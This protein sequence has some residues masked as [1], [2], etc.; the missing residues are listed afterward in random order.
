VGK[1]EGPILNGPGAFLQEEK[2]EGKGMLY[3]LAYREGK[4]ESASC[5]LPPGQKRYL[6]FNDLENDRL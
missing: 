5:S 1:K 6:E 3:Y 2:E 4:E